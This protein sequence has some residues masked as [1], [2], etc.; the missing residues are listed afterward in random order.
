[1]WPR[2]TWQCWMFDPQC[3]PRSQWGLKLGGC[4]S[5]ALPL[6]TRLS[7]CWVSDWKNI[8]RLC[9]SELGIVRH[10]SM[11]VGIPIVCPQNR[12][13]PFGTPDSTRIGLDK[14]DPCQNQLTP[15]RQLTQNTPNQYPQDDS[16]SHLLFTR[17]LCSENLLFLY[18]G[19]VGD[20]YY[21]R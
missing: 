21:F 9:A 14:L 20:I 1:M 13:R 19:C 15:P 6:D 5:G 12:V 7:I 10:V 17:P 8:C 11:E 18:R 2:H 16:K 3:T 4:Q